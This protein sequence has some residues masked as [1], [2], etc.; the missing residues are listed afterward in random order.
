MRLSFGDVCPD[1]DWI[2]LHDCHKR[3]ASLGGL[4][5]IEKLFGNDPG[6][7]TADSGIGALGLGC[8]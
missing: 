5:L 4:A 3:G 1:Y 8:G 2:K 7:R 6:K